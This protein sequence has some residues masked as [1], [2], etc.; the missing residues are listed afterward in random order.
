MRNPTGLDKKAR[1]LGFYSYQDYLNN[2]PHWHIF[3][4]TRI[5]KRC[6]CCGE[7]NRYYLVLHHVSY[8]NLGE[9]R[10]ADVLTLCK[11]CHEHCHEL[12]YRNKATL[13][14]AHEIAKDE[15]K[16]AAYQLGLPLEAA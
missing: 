2:S 3:R 5:G 13:T 11:W 4:M 16:H 12:I 9:E 8:E 7:W 1:V 10:D 15:L 6:W 14:N